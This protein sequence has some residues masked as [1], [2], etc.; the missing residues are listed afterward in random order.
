MLARIGFTIGGHGEAFGSFAGNGS[1]CHQNRNT[2]AL[3]LGL[4]TGNQGAN[5]LVFTVDHGFL[6]NGHRTCG[7]AVGSCMLGVVIGFGGLEQGFGGDA[8]FVQANT[9]QG[10]LFDDQGFHSCVGS[11]FRSQVAAGTAADHDQ[12]VG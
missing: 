6:V 10:L 9:A 5:H 11:S 8:A 2:G 4:H 7:N 12:L 1:L 3:Q